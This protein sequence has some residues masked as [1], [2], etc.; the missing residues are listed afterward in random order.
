MKKVLSIVLAIAMIAS[1][2]TVAFAN[3]MVGENAAATGNSE[4]PVYGTYT[5]NDENRTDMFKVEVLWGS[6]E[7]TYTEAAEQWNTTEH[8]W[9]TAEVG[10]WAPAATDANKVILKNHS[11][12]G[13]TVGL[14]F[15]DDVDDE[16]TI[17][18]TFD[19][20]SIAL[21]AV[22][23]EGT[24]AVVDEDAALLSLV[25]D[26]NDEEAVKVEIGTVTATIA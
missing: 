24:A 8:T 15:T 18:G 6:M 16:A 2:A 11:S 26:Y 17:V 9:D 22:A 14:A 12:E 13:V 3:S 25:G 19:K 7:F 5:I 1:M 4:A 21:D 10:T 20:A 23:G